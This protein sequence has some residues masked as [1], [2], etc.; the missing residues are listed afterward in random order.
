MAK[1]SDFNKFLSNI[2]PS[3]STVSYIS[4]VQNNLRDYLKKH[5]TY[6]D[7]YED[8]FLSGSYAKHTSIRPA[9]DDKKRDVD[10]I[11]V[12][13]H[14]LSEDSSDVLTE[15]LDV[16]QESST[17]ESAEIHHH[18]IGIEFSQVSVDVVPVIQDEED[19]N[20]YYVCDSET[21]EWIKTD[22]KGHKSWSTQVNQ[23]NHGRYKPLVKIF[24][25][26]RRINCPFEVRYPKG[27]TLEKLIA[28]NIGDSE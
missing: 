6:L 10:I 17:Y 7:V 15:L 27:I 28:D 19:V 14:S 13:G 2:E 23:D 20:L 5:K 22:P 26:W 25:W 21:G 18:S 11:V 12:I 24:K 3:S 9:K 1:Q 4:S 8:S 16:L